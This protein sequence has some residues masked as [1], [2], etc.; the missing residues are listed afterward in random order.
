MPNLFD[1]YDWVARIFPAFLAMLPLL[2]LAFVIYPKGLSVNIVAGNTAL[3]VLIFGVV[4]LFANVARFRGEKIEPRLLQRWG[5]WPTTIMLRHR[6]T[7]LDPNT[8]ARYHAALHALSADMVMPTMEEEGSDPS[9]ADNV[10]RSA[11]RRLIEARRGAEY[12]LLHGENASYGFRRNMLG[13]RPI[14]IS[15]ALTLALLTVLAWLAQNYSALPRLDTVIEALSKNW[16][17]PVL[18]AVDLTCA[19]FWA[20][21]ITADFVLQAGRDYAEALFRTLDTPS[22]P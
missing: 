6:D 13:M 7:T 8:K 18:V 12:D 20:F 22:I 21:Q 2:I 10:Y 1:R 15:L 17:L 11:T 9:A 3:A 16:L 19:I 5:G 14:A 4:Y